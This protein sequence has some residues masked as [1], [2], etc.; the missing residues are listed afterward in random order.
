MG[1][2]LTMFFSKEQNT[3]HL[4]KLVDKMCCKKKRHGVMQSMNDIQPPKSVTYE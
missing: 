4:L 3:C 1:R 2:F